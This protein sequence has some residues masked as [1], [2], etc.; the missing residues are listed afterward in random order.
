MIKYAIFDLDGTLCDT[1]EAIRYYVNIT[2]EGYG[3]MP[4]SREECRSFIGNG[5]KK[6]ISR[7]MSARGIDPSLFDE[8]FELYDEIQ[9]DFRVSFHGFKKDVSLDEYSEK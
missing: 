1:L 2:I 8:I 9:D 4:I 6:L 5:A 3:A 7:S